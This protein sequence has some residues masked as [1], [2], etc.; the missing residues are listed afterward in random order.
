MGV[1][2]NDQVLQRDKLIPILLASNHC[3]ELEAL[4]GNPVTIKAAKVP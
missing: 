1:E 2:Q 4:A 3:P